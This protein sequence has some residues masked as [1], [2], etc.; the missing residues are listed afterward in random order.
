MAA[1]FDW[2][3]PLAE[4]TNPAIAA[5]R[6]ARTAS[7]GRSVDF[8]GSR[9]IKYSTPRIEVSE[10]PSQLY[11]MEPVSL[12]TGAVGLVT[13]LTTCVEC[14]EYIDAA[15][16]CGRDLE[17]LTTKFAIE[18][19]RL[20]IW[21][22]SVGILSTTAGNTR[23]ESPHVRPIIEQILHCIRMLFEDT[24]ALTANYG[25]KPTGN[26][27]S[28]PSLAL[29]GPS[30]TAQSVALP[31]RLKAS[32]IRFKSRI[33]QTQKQTSTTKKSK[34][35]IRDKQKFSSFIEDIHQF[36]NGLEAITDSVEMATKRAA[37]VR[38]EL[39]TVE[40]PEDLRLIAEACENGSHQWSDAASEA[41]G[42]SVR[43]ESKYERIREW[44][45]ANSDVQMSTVVDCTKP[46]PS[47]DLPHAPITGFS[48]CND[49]DLG[50]HINQD[51]GS[52]SSRPLLPLPPPPP[53]SVNQYPQLQF[54]RSK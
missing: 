46:E 47:W 10:Q 29:T 51:I 39:S 15:K 26:D 44:M 54:V 40:D 24:N 42:A 5:S 49:D 52:F 41:L 13:L 1:G 9:G 22:E 25:L 16:S 33:D 43:G 48:H 35:A 19:A 37:L 34:W 18:K 14:F 27:V 8:T 38:E 23:V 28:S 45:S 12:S 31:L 50:F 11:L 53:P 7:P 3:Q 30:G 20:L 4:R 32:C 2:L 17:L 6:K 21:G 36:I